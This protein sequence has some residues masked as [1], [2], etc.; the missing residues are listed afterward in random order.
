M[1]HGRDKARAGSGG[2]SAA[3]S[4]HYAQ[5]VSGGTTKCLETLAFPG[6][7]GW[8]GGAGGRQVAPSSTLTDWLGRGCRLAGAMSCSS[9]TLECCCFHW[10]NHRNAIAGGRIQVTIGEDFVKICQEGSSC[11]QSRVSRD[12]QRVSNR[13]RECVSICQTMTPNV[14]TNAGTKCWSE[15]IWNYSGIFL[16][17]SLF[18]TNVPE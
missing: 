15:Y 8:V 18:L 13:W 17:F 9:S 3:A 1:E 16:S 5:T 10:Q 12:C 2:D 11:W 7:G 6:V 14:S 4:S